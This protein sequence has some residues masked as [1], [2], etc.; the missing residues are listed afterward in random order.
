MAGSPF[1][2]A[3][4]G[5][6]REHL[7]FVESMVAAGWLAGLVIPTDADPDALGREDDLDAIRELIAPAPLFVTPRRRSVLAA[8]RLDKPYVVASRP[9]P[10]DLVARV[11]MQVPDANG[12]VVF[13]LKSVDIGR[14]LA[15]ELKLPA[16]LRQHNLEGPYHRALAGSL[17]PPKSW[18]VNLEA[19]RIDRADARLEHSGWLRGIADISETDAATRSGRSDVPVAHVPTFA[20]GP[21]MALAEQPWR[22]PDNPVVVFVGALQVGTNHDAIEWFAEQVWPLIRAEHPGAVW[23]IV[24]RSPAARVHDLVARTEGAELHPDVADPRDYLRNASVA[25]N[26][27][28]SGSG[29]N[30]KLVEYL[31]VGLPVVSTTKGQAGL[32]VSAGSDLMVADDPTEF[33]GQVNHLLASAADSQR[34]GST[35]LATAT[36]ILDVNGSLQIMADLMERPARL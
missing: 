6:E 10:A 21:R 3:Q 7:G 32:G 13:A 26:P 23:Q 4:D 28:V 11:S 17:T 36:R 25:V 14:R 9:V 12:L 5:G 15:E 31:S 24:G 8:T 18:L 22:R 20:L 27:T 33:A 34:V 16:V 1:M 30:I 2:P 29:V 19:A 35:G